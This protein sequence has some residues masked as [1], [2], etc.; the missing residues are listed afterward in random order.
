MNFVLVIILF[1]LMIYIDKKRGIKLFLSI[2]FNFC[3]LMIV[4][5]L[6]AL[7]IN[8]IICSLIGCLVI[9]YIILYFVNEKNN[10]TISSMKS[11]IIVLVILAVLI[12]GVTYISRIAGFGYESYEEINM[13]S[14]DVRIDFSE[15][16][17][18]MIL[19][20]LIGA[21][22][23]TAIAISSALFEVYDNNKKLSKKELFLSGMNI[24]RDVLCT[25]SNTL[26][27]AFLGDFM[28]LII[29]FS[30]GNYSLL[31]IVN[32]KTFV[33]EIIRILFSAIGCIIVIPIS[34][35][36]SARNVD[37]VYIDE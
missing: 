34:A 8:P 30:K 9:S 2:I 15:I 37:K 11:I 25:T 5:Y 29:W 20:S 36:I 12:Y 14:Y 31:D 6:I 32:A 1:L 17:V 19:I 24:G 21:T 13:F 23:D 16:A 18:S 7:G 10:K 33:A 4:F 26:L 27:F 35:Y 22:V 3:I 28:T